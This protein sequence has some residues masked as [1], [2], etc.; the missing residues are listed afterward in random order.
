MSSTSRFVPVVEW[1]D[2]RQLL[3]M[4]G[5]RLAIAYLTACGWCVEAHRYR[6]GRHDVDLIIRRERLVAFVEVKTR[7]G[8]RC[9]SGLEAV[10]WRKQRDIARVAS[11]WRLRYGCPGDEYRFDLVAIEYP[12]AA[13]PI[14][15]HVAD[16]WRVRSMWG[17]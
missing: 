16:A 9:G 6:L 8:D 10:G 1:Q 5:E 14:I 2:Q 11:V 4:R 15:N 13:A 3:G 12:D 7:R 17:L